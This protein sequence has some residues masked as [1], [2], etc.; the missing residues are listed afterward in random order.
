LFSFIVSVRA[1]QNRL[2]FIIFILFLTP[3]PLH[4]SRFCCFLAFDFVKNTLLFLTKML[5]FQAYQPNRT[6]AMIVLRWR[7]DKF[8]AQEKSRPFTSEGRRNDYG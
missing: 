4:I 5:P 2:K 7:A 1:E 3:S 6:S 8:A